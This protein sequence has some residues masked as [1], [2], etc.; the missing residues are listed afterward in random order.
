[1]YTSKKQDEVN[2]IMMSTKVDGVSIP[3]LVNAKPLK[4][5]DRLV[6]ADPRMPDDDEASQPAKKAKK[7]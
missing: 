4:V 6:K 7:D 1:M 3:I 2:M 5:G